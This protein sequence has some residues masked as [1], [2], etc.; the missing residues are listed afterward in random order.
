MK[1]YTELKKGMILKNHR[2][3]ILI[4]LRTIQSKEYINDFAAW[5]VM[6]FDGRR[7]LLRFRYSDSLW[8]QYDILEEER[9]KNWQGKKR[10]KKVWED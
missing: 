5:H 4:L 7:T 1:R 2:G 6:F 10:K 9:R 3:V 8:R